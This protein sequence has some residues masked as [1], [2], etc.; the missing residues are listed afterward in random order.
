[1][2][3]HSG[4][5]GEAD[6]S[7]VEAIMD[8]VAEVTIPDA[9]R[10]LVFDPH[11]DDNGGDE[12]EEGSHGSDRDDD[13]FGPD[14]GAPVPAPSG[15]P[16]TPD[17]A[18]ETP[19]IVEDSI[20]PDHVVAMPPMSPSTMLVDPHLIRDCKEIF[21]RLPEFSLTPR[22]ELKRDDAVIGKIYQISGKSLKMVCKM[23]TASDDDLAMMSGKSGKTPGRDC[24]MH[25]DIKG[26]LRR[27][28]ARLVQWCI[29]GCSICDTLDS[30]TFWQHHTAA[31]EQQ[32][33]CRN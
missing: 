31:T 5:P 13:P 6:G 10:D 16:S 19:P 27:C 14:F 7:V 18:A 17:G 12:S 4:E 26:D 2:A 1:M 15:E 8:E 23:H 28:E 29:L 22:W 25:I 11:V 24:K 32:V 33:L 9:C 20:A 30:S 21:L 3:G